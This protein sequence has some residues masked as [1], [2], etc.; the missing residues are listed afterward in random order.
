MGKFKPT[1]QPALAGPGT[2]IPVFFLGAQ[3]WPFCAAERWPL[4]RALMQFGTFSTLNEEHSTANGSG[5]SFPALPTY[6]LRTAKYD[7]QYVR[8]RVMEVA[9]HEGK[10]LDQ[11]DAEEQ[12]W[13][14]A[15]NPKGQWPFI[16]VNGQFTQIGP[17]YPPQVLA[18]QQ[19]GDLR[20]A[21]QGGTATPATDAINREAA[22]ITR[23]ICAADG[24]QPAD[25]CARAF[26]G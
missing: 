11:P 21:L 6:D 4:T 22:T 20:A 15:F 1:G 8:L 10:P 5:T 2:P 16:M 18:G 24:G 7:S 14:N 26:G 19:F 12:Q 25:V 23:V 17:G 9:D 13:L 3:F